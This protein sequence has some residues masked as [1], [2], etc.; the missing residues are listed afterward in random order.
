M[1][2]RP[3]KDSEYTKDI[4]VSATTR[5][6][7]FATG[8]LG[9]CI[10]LSATSNSG[11]ILPLAVVVSAA[12]GTAVVWRSD[13]KTDTEI[14]QHQMLQIRERLTN[15]ETIVSREDLDLQL[16]LKHLES[17]DRIS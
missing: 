1:S 2:D 16:K 13:R 9:I 7:A 4:R 12:T 3:K 6:W 10:P 11:A 15:L 8:M 14:E 17:R 5:I